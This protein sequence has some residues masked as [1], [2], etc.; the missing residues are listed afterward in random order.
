MMTLADIFDALT[1]LDRPYKPALGASVALDL[2][3]EDVDQGGLD[4]DLF[5]IFVHTRVYEMPAAV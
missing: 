2:M 5:D 1:A 3:R 4:A